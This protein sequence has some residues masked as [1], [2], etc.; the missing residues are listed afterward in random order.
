MAGLSSLPAGACRDRVITGMEEQA[1]VM[2]PVVS[3]GE[4]KAWRELCI[5]SII[6]I[7]CNGNDLCLH[8]APTVLHKRSGFCILSG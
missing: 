6:T 2:T 7:V 4:A 3:P 5:L 8:K 1:R